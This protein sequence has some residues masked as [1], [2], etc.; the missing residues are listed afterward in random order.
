MNIAES[1]RMALEMIRAHKLRSGFTIL[2]TVLGVTFLIAVI[3]LIQGV[4]VYVRDA[5]VSQLYGVNSVMLRRTPSVQIDTDRAARRQYQRRPRLTMEDA[6][7]LAERIETPGILAIGASRTGEVTGPEGMSLENVRVTG[8]SASYFRVRSMNVELGRAF[9]QQEDE[10]GLPVAVIGRDVADQ[11]FPNTNPLGST[12]RINRFPYQVIGVLERQGSLFGMSMDSQVIAPARSQLNGWVN[13]W[14]VLDEITFQVPNAVYMPA[15]MA[16]IEGWMRIRHRLRPDEPNTF[17]V[18]TAEASL[19]FWTQISQI[20]FIALPGLIGISLVVGGVV[21]MNLM[22][23]S[24]TERTREI[25]LRKSL[26]ARRRDILRQFV[27]EA[28]T[29]SGVGGVIGIVLGMGLAALTAALSPLPAEVA[30]WSIVLGLL[31]GIGVGMVA[32]TY[33]ALRA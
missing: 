27:V 19:S 1:I 33:P 21:I 9:Q 2:G 22:L 17:E 18:E 12:I 10:R 24:V 7:W 6:G 32:G 23:V 11:L 5:L 26:G 31:L 29:L 15:A 16:E 25:G 8:A 4:D 14:N 28:G 3:T 13:P 30:P 20:L